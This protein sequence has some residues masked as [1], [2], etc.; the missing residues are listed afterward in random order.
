MTGETTFTGSWSTGITEHLLGAEQGPRDHTGLQDHTGFLDYGGLAGQDIGTATGAYQYHEPA[1]GTFGTAHLFG[2]DLE[3]PY[4]TPAQGVFGGQF[5][6]TGELRFG[7]FA[8]YD[9]SAGTDSYLSVGHDHGLDRAGPDL[10]EEPVGGE[11]RFDDER[12][13]PE[14]A[15]PSPVA[16]G[17]SPFERP[18]D[19]PS[20]DEEE[21][22]PEE[23]EPDEFEPSRRPLARW[24]VLTGVVLVLAAGLA[25]GGVLFLSQRREEQPKREESPITLRD[26][27][28]GVGVT[29]PPGWR[30]DPGTPDTDAY[31]NKRPCPYDAKATCSDGAVTIFFTTAQNI[32]EAANS[33]RGT[34][35]KLAADNKTSLRLVRQDSSPVAGH[36]ARSLRFAE[37]TG[38][39]GS[40]TQVTVIELGVQSQVI[41]QFAVIHLRTLDSVVP[42][43][44]VDQILRSLTVDRPAASS[45]PTASASS[46]SPSPRTRS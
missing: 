37:L 9:V 12:A 3:R 29:L 22:G 21:D 44:V 16:F 24:I 14:P 7:A 46:A 17:S 11:D 41:R 5:A 45:S 28:T 27:K 2:G 6:E 23:D 34:L 30:A 1:T 10:P 33:F 42:E 8:G 36:P 25:A 13:E 15:D 32:D 35:E 19:D 18:A 38:Q 39:Q 43:P 4:Q 20:T 26:A 31:R 40:H